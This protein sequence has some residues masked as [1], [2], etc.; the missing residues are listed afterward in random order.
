MWVDFSRPAAI[1][2]KIDQSETDHAHSWSSD[3]IL[4]LEVTKYPPALREFYSVWPR[5][6]M[7][8][9]HSACLLSEIVSAQ[10]AFRCPNDPDELDHVS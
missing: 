8:D 6:K 2:A 7:N 9:L 10:S 5:H 3:A 1:L 4:Y